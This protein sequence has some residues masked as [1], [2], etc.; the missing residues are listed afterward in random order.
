MSL[1]D[2]RIKFAYHPR[3][4]VPLGELNVTN[5]VESLNVYRTRRLQIMVLELHLFL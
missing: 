4:D 3:V 2:I 1:H 5:V